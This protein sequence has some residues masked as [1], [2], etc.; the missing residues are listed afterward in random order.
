M[1][2]GD[3]DLHM[4]AGAYALD[5]VADDE[6]ARFTEHLA[7]CALCRAE[8]G[9]FR[10]A[11]ARL[12]TAQA[13]RPRPELRDP[14]IRSALNTGQAGPV[15]AERQGSPTASR[16]RRVPVLLTAAA[17][18]VAAAIGIGTHYADVADQRSATRARTVATVL[19]A[20]DAVLRM[21][22]VRSGGMAVVVTSRR[23]HMA[24]FF[25]N[26]LRSLP[27]AKRYELWLMGPNGERP[28]GMLAVH[29]KDMAGPALITGMSAGDMV[30]LTVEPASGSLRPTSAPVVLVRQGRP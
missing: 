25:A 1:A 16:R 10:E 21:A 28:A 17:A 14:V 19:S 5:A 9:E 4:L 11:A 26:G 8:V 30:G 12:G 2:S 29:R 27:G 24:V 22:H 13:V 18:A 3:H 20:P 6:R 15:I 7:G 23:E